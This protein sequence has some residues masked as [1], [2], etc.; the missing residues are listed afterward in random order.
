MQI[1][2]IG[3]NFYEMSNPVLKIKHTEE[4]CSG[5]VLG[6]CIFFSIKTYVG[7]IH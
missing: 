3:D 1:V 5:L 4:N 2:F 7:G 6:D